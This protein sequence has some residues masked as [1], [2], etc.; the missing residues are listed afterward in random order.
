MQRTSERREQNWKDKT[1]AF[2]APLP[3]LTEPRREPNV[4]RLRIVTYSVLFVCLLWLASCSTQVSV[5]R[6]H[7]PEPTKEMM[8]KPVPPK[9][10]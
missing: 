7:L 9:P 4:W 8:A 10:I 6:P 2:G 3:P 5:T 1:F